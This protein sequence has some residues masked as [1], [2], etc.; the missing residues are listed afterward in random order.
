MAMS[1]DEFLLLTATEQEGCTEGP[2]EKEAAKERFVPKLTD[3]RSIF[4]VL[5]D[6]VS[7]RI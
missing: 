1:P 7:A 5:A 6:W 4:S 2:A 3:R